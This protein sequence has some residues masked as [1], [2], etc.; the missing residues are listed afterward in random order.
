MGA[1]DWLG[2]RRGAGNGYGYE[3]RV[4]HVHVRGGVG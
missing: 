2:V 3:D 4:K 1:L